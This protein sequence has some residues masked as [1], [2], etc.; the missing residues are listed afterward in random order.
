MA[1]K[2]RQGRKVQ[3]EAIEWLDHCSV[4]GSGWKHGEVVY[5]L[6]PIVF[7]TLGIVIKET[8][9]YLVIVSSWDVSETMNEKNIHGEVCIVKSCILRRKKLRGLESYIY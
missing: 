9:D 4:S 1:A 5:Q 8:K 2:K 7:R 3:A 6:E